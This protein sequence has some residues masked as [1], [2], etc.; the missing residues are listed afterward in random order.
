MDERD[1]SGEKGS[2]VLCFSSNCV[3]IK[4]RQDYIK[5]GFMKRKDL[6]IWVGGQLL[7]SFQIRRHFYFNFLSPQ[8]WVHTE[9]LNVKVKIY[10]SF[11]LLKHVYRMLALEN[12]LISEELC[13]FRKEVIYAAILQLEDL[14]PDHL[15]NG[16]FI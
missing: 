12:D 1:Q 9:I 8:L 13:K 2:L 5:L 14:S 6:F 15:S 4:I 11:S 3:C 7:V 16:H 10:K